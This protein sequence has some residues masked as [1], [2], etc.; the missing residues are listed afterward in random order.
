MYEQMQRLVT[1]YGYP[2]TPGSEGMLS[3]ELVDIWYEVFKGYS[4]NQV[5]K[6]ITAHINAD[7]SLA[8]VF[9]IPGRIRK[10]IKPEDI[11]TQEEHRE[12]L[13]KAEESE[14]EKE[15]ERWESLTDEERETEMR[16]REES[17]QRIKQILKDRGLIDG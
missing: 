8:G 16:E 17:R 11:Y 3:K 7:D 6:A 1:V 4:C 5:S 15:R 14:R 2:K 12:F 10:R 13:R 9:P